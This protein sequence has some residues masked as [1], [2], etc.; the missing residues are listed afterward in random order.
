MQSH[1]VNALLCCYAVD[2]QP[3]SYAAENAAPAIDPAQ[4]ERDALLAIEILADI[5]K[6]MET[7]REE[8]SDS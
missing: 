3:E 7:I 6:T 1:S 4:Q 5:E 8:N 2:V